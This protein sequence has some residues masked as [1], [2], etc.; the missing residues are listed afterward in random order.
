MERP[1]WR[2]DGSV[3]Y[4]YCWSSPA[5]SFSVLSPAG[6]AAIFYCLNYDTSPTWRARFLNLFPLRT[7]WPSY[8]PRTLSSHFVASYDLLRYGGVF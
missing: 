2:D 3:I 4:S 8:T 1:V 6:L 5:K 7:G